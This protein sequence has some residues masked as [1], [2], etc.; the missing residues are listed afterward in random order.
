MGTA[1]SLS[2]IKG[3]IKETF[4]VSNCDILID[5]DYA[6]ILKYHRDNKNEITIVA[7]LKNY[8]IPYGIIVTGDNGSLVEMQEKP[9][10]TFKIKLH[11]HIL[12]VIFHFHSPII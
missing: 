9:D 2:L 11:E 3:K 10:L 8:A 5:E 7:A 6:E 1:G 4:F 12:K